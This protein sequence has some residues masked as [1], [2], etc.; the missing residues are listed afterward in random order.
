MGTITYSADKLHD[1]LLNADYC[2]P[3]PSQPY[4]IAEKL[5][6]EGLYQQVDFLY[7]QISVHPLTNQRHLCDAL[8]FRKK[9]LQAKMEAVLDALSPTRSICALVTKIFCPLPKWQK[10]QQSALD[11]LRE[12]YS[13]ELQDW[14]Y[15]AL[16]TCT[17]PSLV[18]FY[19][20]KEPGNIHAVLLF[21]KPTSSEETMLETLREEDSQ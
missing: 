7:R 21:Y 9:P 20:P 2:K 17:E 18:Q 10:K 5:K 8:C 13:K 15:D 1:P 16:E 11:T 14:N 19:L 6:K 4:A 12:E 3:D